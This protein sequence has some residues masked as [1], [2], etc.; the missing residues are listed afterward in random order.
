MGYSQIGI[1]G[2]KGTPGVTG[3]DWRKMLMQEYPRFI[4][5]AQIR[6]RFNFD[7]T[8]TITDKITG[9]KYE[10]DV[11]KDYDV[12]NETEE[13]IKKLIIDIRNSKLDELV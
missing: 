4:I 11:E 9:K 1:T 2:S 10:F 5:E 7:L 3:I 13:F 6:D 12:I 8:V